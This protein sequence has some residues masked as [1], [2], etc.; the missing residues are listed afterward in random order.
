MDGLKDKAK[1]TTASV[2]DSFRQMATDALSALDRLAGAIQGGNFL[3]ILS[4]VLNF[5]L[6]LGGMGVFGKGVQANINASPRANGGNAS[7][8][9]P[10]IVGEHRPELFVPDTNGRIMPQ[11]PS[12]AARVVVEASPYFDVRVDGRIQTAAPVIADAGA[13]VAQG[14]MNRTATRRVA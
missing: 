3:S 2:R 6:Q 14:R 4:G 13:N 5:G 8:G 9:T 11:V 12:G 7:A 10:Y 1:D